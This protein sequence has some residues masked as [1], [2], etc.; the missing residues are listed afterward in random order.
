MNTLKGLIWL[1]V[2]LWLDL[3]QASIYHIFWIYPES[4]TNSTKASS[5][6]ESLKTAVFVF[7]ISTFP[8]SKQAAAVEEVGNFGS[9]AG[10]VK[11]REE[12]PVPLALRRI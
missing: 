7:C 8:E 5:Q 2:T 10:K 6:A 12:L 1:A 4:R 11:D 9:E 3:K